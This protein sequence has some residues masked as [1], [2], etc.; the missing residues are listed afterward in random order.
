METRIL[1]NGVEMPVLEINFFFCSQRN[2]RYAI[3]YAI[4]LASFC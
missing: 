1:N 3:R 2:K 4:L